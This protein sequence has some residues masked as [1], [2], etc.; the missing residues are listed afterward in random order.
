MVNMLRYYPGRNDAWLQSQYGEILARKKWLLLY[1]DIALEESQ[2]YWLCVFVCVCVC[3]CVVGV[4]V[5]EYMCSPLA[6]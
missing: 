3:V 6:A 5:C 4:C 1:L 2:V